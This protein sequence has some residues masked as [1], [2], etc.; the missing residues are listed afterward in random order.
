MLRT[1]PVLLH[2]TLR[3][4]KCIM[5][6]LPMITC[7]GCR[8]EAIRWLYPLCATQLTSKSLCFFQL[9]E[10][11]FYPGLKLGQASVAQLVEEFPKRIGPSAFSDHWKTLAELT[12]VDVMEQQFDFDGH[13]LLAHNAA[14]NVSVLVLRLEDIGYWQEIMKQH[15]PNFVVRTQNVG[16][17]K[18][19]ADQYEA[20]EKS[21]IYIYIFPP[22]ALRTIRSHKHN[23][24][25]TTEERNRF[26]TLERHPA[27]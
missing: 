3:S 18:G 7:R 6:R 10:D 9:L 20:F 27:Q 16:S 12:G 14:T 5:Q 26:E 21:H 17:Q 1:C 22:D 11:G 25:Y 19:Y 2:R 4:L 23:H 13:Q 24:F 8:L 15:V